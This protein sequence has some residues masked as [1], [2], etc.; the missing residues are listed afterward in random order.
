MV[1]TE[2]SI[3]SEALMETLDRLLYACSTFNL[4]EIVAILHELP[5]DYAPQNTGTSD[6]LWSEKQG[7]EKS[8]DSSFEV[9]V[10]T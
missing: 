9:G 1:A 7:I 5:L 6:L 8:Q 2:V 10:R 4:P 3:P